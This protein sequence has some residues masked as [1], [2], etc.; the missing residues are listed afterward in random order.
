MLHMCN[1]SGDPLTLTILMMPRNQTAAEYTGV[2]RIPRKDFFYI[3]IKF[4][5]LDV[6]VACSDVYSN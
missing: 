4:Q 2:V 3:Y 5:S 1:M 6:C